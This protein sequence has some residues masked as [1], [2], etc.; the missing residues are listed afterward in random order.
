MRTID[1]EL[2]PERAIC[3]ILY[4]QL[5]ALVIK[6]LAKNLYR[7]IYRLQDF[8][9]G[10]NSRNIRSLDAYT[11][12]STLLVSTLLVAISE[13]GNGDGMKRIIGAFRASIWSG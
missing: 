7:S 2:Q 3:S 5:F 8:G 11:I 12:Y 6:F 9:C 13:Q 1:I 10:A 4:V